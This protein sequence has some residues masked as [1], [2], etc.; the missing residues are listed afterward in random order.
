MAR[1]L[2]WFEAGKVSQKDY[3]E[4]KVMFERKC[5]SDPRYNLGEYMLDY[6]EKD[7]DLLIAG[8]DGS[9]QIYAS[10]PRRLDVLKHCTIAQIAFIIF[11][12]N[13]AAG[14]SQEGTMADKTI[15]RQSLTGSRTR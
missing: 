15:P 2:T 11:M 5:A 14:V 8:M 12:C 3:E 10:K 7:V 13:Y 1:A 9:A 4:R 6:C